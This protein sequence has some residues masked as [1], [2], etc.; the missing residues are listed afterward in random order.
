MSSSAPSTSDPR[1][2]RQVAALTEALLRERAARAA[3]NA[4]V[5]ALTAQLAARSSGCAAAAP[6]VR[7]LRGA[8]PHTVDSFRWPVDDGVQAE[9]EVHEFQT[10]SK[11][12]FCGAKF[13]RDGVRRWW[14]ANRARVA[15]GGF[16]GPT[17]PSKAGSAEGSANGV[18][19]GLAASAP[20]LG[21]AARR[22]ALAECGEVSPS[23]ESSMRRSLTA[24]SAA[25]Q[26]LEA[27]EE[28]S[29]S[30][31]RSTPTGADG[32]DGDSAALEST[33]GGTLCPLFV[34][35][36]EAAPAAGV[37]AS[38]AISAGGALRLTEL[39]SGPQ[40]PSQASD[41]ATQQGSAPPLLDGGDTPT[42][43]FS[44]AQPLHCGLAAV[45]DPLRVSVSGA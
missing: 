39:D 14:A 23:G 5:A 26:S 21:E 8:G 12:R 19:L 15:A 31:A 36:P 29:D 42:H 1:P 43:A 13:D 10:V 18:A 35:E 17:P 25:F 2:T 6:L 24:R 41:A 9:V 4:Q 16:R 28:V 11:I 44:A 33:H 32:V 37:V 34:A 45:N 22:A 30:P 27:L 7:A 40:T 3:A 38:P 20:E